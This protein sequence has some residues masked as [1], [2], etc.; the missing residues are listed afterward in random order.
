M[1]NPDPTARFTE[2][3][4]DYAAHR[5]SYPPEVIGV[6]AREGVLR[7]ADVVAD[8]G[9][10]T[11]ILTALLL[12]HGNTVQALLKCFLYDGLRAHAPVGKALIRRPERED[13]GRV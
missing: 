11:G 6:L 8:V 1:T 7:P 12:D 10:G 9:S 5:P 2:R 4:A 3:V 13:A